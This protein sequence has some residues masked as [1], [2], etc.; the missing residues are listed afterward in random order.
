[1]GRN[2]IIFNKDKN[3]P[4]ARYWQFSKKI[5]NF[6]KQEFEEILSKKCYSVLYIINKIAYKAREIA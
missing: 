2:V 4:N 5:E 3:Q 6:E 1:M